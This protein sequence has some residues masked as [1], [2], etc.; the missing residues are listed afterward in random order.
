[1]ATIPSRYQL[2]LKAIDSIYEQADEVRIYLNNFTEV[3]KELLRDKIT[4][5]IGKDLM[6]TGKL[7]WALNHDEY[8]FCI[9][10]DLRYPTTY[11]QYM[12][13]VLN[14][15]NDDICA[16]LHG[17]I[18][19][20]T[21]INSYFKGILNSFQCLAG[22]PISI[23]VHVIGNGVSVFNTNKVKIDYS[24]FKYLYMDDIEVSLQL[25]QQK[26]PALVIS[27]DANYLGYE[28]PNNIE[29][30]QTLYTMYHNND[31]TQTERANSIKW[32]IFKI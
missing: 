1:M 5:H 22:F 15:F 28:E 3:P 24:K 27:H 8:Y 25:Q 6:S 30:V 26:I 29:G 13:S 10:D 31:S 17:K 32:K 14:K 11:A 12:I 21:P 19:K 4:T 9:D 7:F 23:F 20:P 16:S 18:L 2:A